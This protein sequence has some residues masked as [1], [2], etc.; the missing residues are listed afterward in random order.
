[1]LDLFLLKLVAR[2]ALILLASLAG[3]RWGETV[4]GWFVGLPLTSGPVVFFLA[5][6]Q[7]IGFAAAT[8]RGSLA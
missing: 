2:P 3:R 6:E 7:G 8:T 4:G 1:M 5:L